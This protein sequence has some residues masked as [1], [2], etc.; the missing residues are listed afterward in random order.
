MRA[1]ILAALALAALAGGCVTPVEQ[2]ALDE[3][4]C[5]SFGFRPATDGFANCLL[6]LDLDRSATRRARFDNFYGPAW[7]Y[8]RW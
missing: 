2:R 1:K 5:Q 4:R 8:R 3:G 7:P 6:E